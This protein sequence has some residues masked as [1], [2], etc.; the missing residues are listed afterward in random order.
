MGLDT[1]G[2]D[3][4]SVSGRVIV[5]NNDCTSLQHVFAIGDIAEVSHIDTGSY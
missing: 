2:V 1:V 4:S 5:D 3:I